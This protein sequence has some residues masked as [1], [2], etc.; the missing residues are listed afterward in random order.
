MAGYRGRQVLLLTDVGTREE[1]TL[2]E[3]GDGRVLL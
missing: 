1:L 2:I 3:S